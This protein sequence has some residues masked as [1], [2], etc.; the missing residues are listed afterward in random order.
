MRDFH[1]LREAFRTWI[2]QHAHRTLSSNQTWET[3]T[4]SDPLE[5]SVP[6]QTRVTRK[7]P[8]TRKSHNAFLSFEPCERVQ[9]RQSLPSTDSFKPLSTLFSFNVQ[10]FWR[11]DVLKR[12]RW[13]LEAL[14]PLVSFLSRKRSTF[15]SRWTPGA[16]QTRETVG[17]V[18]SWRTQN[19]HWTGETRF[20][21]STRKSSGTDVSRYSRV[22]YEIHGWISWESLQSCKTR[23][24]VRSWSSRKSRVSSLSSGSVTSVQTRKTRTSSRTRVTRDSF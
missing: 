6:G 13:P 16:G 20:P 19:P 1:V 5:S 2:S 11:V 22:R 18:Q 9:T 21:L 10:V 4:S 24:S 12:P 3:W 7:S 8:G 14:I 23:F 17:P 15:F